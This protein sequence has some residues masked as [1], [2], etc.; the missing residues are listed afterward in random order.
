MKQLVGSDQGKYSFDHSSGTITFTE[1]QSLSLANILLITNVTRGEIL[2]SF[3]DSTLG[4]SIVDNIIDL[5]ADTS[6]MSSSDVLQIWIDIPVDDQCD[7]RSLLRRILDALL[8]PVGYDSS[9]NRSRQT[10]VIESGTVTTVSTCSTV[11]NANNLIN[12]DGRPGSMAVN[13]LDELAWIS[14]VRAKIS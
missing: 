5:E 1:L 4:A 12:I 10:T 11:T 14:A 3:A 7:N 9:Q 2:Y 6:A 13:A 8:T